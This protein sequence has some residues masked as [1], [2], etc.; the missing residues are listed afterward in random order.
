MIKVNLTIN[1]IDFSANSMKTMDVIA[2]QSKTKKVIGV[3]NTLDRDTNKV[4]MAILAVDSDNYGKRLE[5]YSYDTC[6]FFKVCHTD[7]DENCYD[8]T[9]SAEEV[10]LSDAINDIK[11]NS[12]IVSRI[13]DKGMTAWEAIHKACTDDRWL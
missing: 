8:I 4:G 13:F 10:A 2:A 6:K 9:Y 3:F 11:F 7:E 1:P 12:N 5:M